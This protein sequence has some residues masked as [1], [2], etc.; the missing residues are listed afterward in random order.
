MNIR[1][2]TPQDCADLLAIYTPY[3]IHTAITFEYEIPDMM[4]FESRIKDTLSFYPYLAAVENEKIIGYA[5]ASQFHTRAAYSHSA[6]LSIYIEQNCR[7]HGIGKAL[8]ESLFQILRL[9]NI[10]MVHACIATCDNIDEHLNND[11]IL[12]HEKMGFSHSGKHELCG[13]KFNKWYNV[14]WMDKMIEAHPEQ[15]SAF[16]PF[17]KLEEYSYQDFLL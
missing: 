5:Y 2:A 6:E 8:Y 1:L 16:I 7:Q 12:F 10:Y 15:V 11:S 4:E 3:I 14:I 13:Y 9:Q 17:S